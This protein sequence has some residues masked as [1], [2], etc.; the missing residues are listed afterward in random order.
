MNFRDFEFA[1]GSSH[2]FQWI[3]GKVFHFDTSEL[4]DVDVL[5]ALVST[6]EFRDDY[7]GGGVD[8]GGVV[9]GPYRLDRISPESYTRVGANDVSDVIDRWLARCGE[10]SSDLRRE[11]SDRI[12]IPAESAASCYIL[13]DLGESA[14]VGYA[15]IHNEF[16]EIVLVDRSER[17]VH[18]IVASDD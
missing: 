10:I 13:G 1:P 14:T 6:T 15:D 9:H 5:E 18:L 8:P 2:C 17:R 11:I 16:H 3:D 4:D 12:I 7:I